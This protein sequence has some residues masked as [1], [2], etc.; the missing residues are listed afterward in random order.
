MEKKPILI[1]G[2]G[3]LLC[4]DEGVGV[5]LIRRL[6]NIAL[7]PQVE[8]VD[9][10]TA[11]FELIEYF[12]NRKKVIL[13]D[14][15]H[16]EAEPGSL[17]RLTMDDFAQADLGP[18]A[19]HQI[20]LPELFHHVRKLDSP[21]EVVIFGVVPKDIQNFKIGLSPQVEDRL[22]EIISL[23]IKEISEG[24]GSEKKDL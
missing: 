18:F 5:H 24:P 12:R 19:V 23:V 17:F 7:P 21:P 10:G 15:L 3:N 13:I 2:V 4:S 22:P 8:V 11:G 1:L 14:A 9:G 20:G 6:Q 16:M